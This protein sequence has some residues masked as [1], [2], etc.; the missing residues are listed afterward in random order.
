MK[1]KLFSKTYFLLT[2]MLTIE[3]FY[4]LVVSL[5]TWYIYQ[6][7]RFIP[8]TWETLY[9][10]LGRVQ[11]ISNAFMFTIFWSAD[12]KNDTTIQEKCYLHCTSTICLVGHHIQVPVLRT[13]DVYLNEHVS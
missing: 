11:Y 2:R 9:L 13:Y 7:K 6:L 3:L 8:R 12:S 5:N 1:K 4:V 10:E